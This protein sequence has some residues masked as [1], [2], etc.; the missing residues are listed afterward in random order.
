MPM[1]L[2][3]RRKPVVEPREQEN[4]AQAPETDGRLAPAEPQREPMP[5]EPHEGAEGTRHHGGQAEEETAR[6]EQ[7][8][9]IVLFHAAQY[10]KY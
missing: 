2:C 10:S 1:R 5:G 4:A 3:P 7:F 6:Q 8:E 9:E